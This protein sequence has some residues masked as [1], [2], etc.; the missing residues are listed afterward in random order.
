[1]NSSPGSAH[2]VPVFD[3]RG[4]TRRIRN[5]VIDLETRAQSLV[6]VRD[7]QQFTVGGSIETGLNTVNLSAQK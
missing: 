4:L 7:T 5:R 1:M 2:I 6:F 3:E